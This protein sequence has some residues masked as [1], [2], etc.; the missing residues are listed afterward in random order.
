MKLL[1]SIGA[2]ILGT[3]GVWVYVS[4]VK[5]PAV[6]SNPTVVEEG[7]R[8]APSEEDSP[9]PPSVV[10]ANLAI[11]WDIAFLP[12]G[13]MLV[14][15]RSGR[16]LHIEEDK[17]FPIEGIEHIGEAGLLGIALHPDFENNHYLYLYQTTSAGDGLK[18]RVV[19]YIY[20]AGE[21][22]LDTVILDD[23][24]GARYHDG[25]RLAFG[26]D[27]KL[28]VG[29]GDATDEATAQDPQ[30]LGGS[31]LRVDDDGSI[32]TDNPFGNAVYSYGH[33]NPQ[34]ITWDDEGRLW[35]TEHGRSG[36]RSGYD[37]INLITP[38]ANY[39]WPDSEGDTVAEDT[40]AP[41][42]HSTASVTWAPASAL[43]HEGSI[44]FGGLKGE[45]LYEAVLDGEKVI[46]LREH[47]AGEYGRIRSITLG[48][49]G[50]FYLTT[51][52][53]DGRGDPI[54]EDDRIIRIDPRWLTAN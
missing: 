39:G 13:D 30:T 35:I 25:G 16:L 24:P 54:A 43:Y 28:Y 2:L 4:Y 46:E 19:R 42:L 33:R 37:E 14:T 15:E 17:A 29:V 40:V 5:A 18:N 22:T 45:T 34:G 7:E 6:D 47:L 10:V 3:V 31:I 32:P 12:S 53:R 38:G 41:A 36:V 27:G 44:F 8:T 49:D 9:Q 11:P 23:L 52:N 21:L 48:P 26:P 51:S 20:E 1:A 50:F